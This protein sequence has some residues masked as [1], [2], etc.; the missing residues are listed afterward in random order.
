MK[1]DIRDCNKRIDVVE[2]NANAQIIKRDMQNHVL[3]R[4][5][6]RGDF[7]VSGMPVL[8]NIAVAIATFH[9]INLS[10]QDVTYVCYINNHMSL[11]VGFKTPED[12]FK[13][14][15]DFLKEYSW[16]YQEANTC[17]IKSNILSK[18]PKEFRNYFQNI[19]NHDLN[20]FPLVHLPLKAEPM[21]MEFRRRLSSLIPQEAFADPPPLE[22][23]S[24]FKT[25]NF[26]KMNL[27]KRHEILRLAQ[28]I[29]TQLQPREKEQSQQQT[30]ESDQEKVVLID[31]G[32]GLGYLSEMLYKLNHNY[33]I[34]GLE[35]DPVRVEAAEKRL[36]AYMPGAKEAI[37]YRQQFI[38]ENSKDFINES[39]TELLQSNYCPRQDTLR[40]PTTQAIIG[41]HACADL[42]ITS[43]KLFLRMPQ[44]RHLIIMP[45]CYHKMQMCAG[46]MKFH[47]FPL[48]R[49]LQ[50]V[51]VPDEDDDDKASDSS[52]INNYSSYLNRPFLRL[53]CQ[54]TLKR[55]HKC[56]VEQH[57]RHA[58]EMF[59]RAM[60]EA[61]PHKETEIVVKCKEK[62]D[63]LKENIL[64]FNTIR[65]LYQLQETRDVSRR[66]VVDWSE[67]HVRE[68]YMLVAKYGDGE[69]LAEGLTCL[70]TAIQK[71]CENLVLYDRLCFMEETA[72][73]LNLN[74][75]VRYEKLMDE[76]LSPR[77]Y[78]LIAEKL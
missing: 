3:H 6:N 47:N 33:L 74:I 37:H 35:S 5:L 61:L 2:S 24:H 38:T 69:K 68:F 40:Q 67:E 21:L 43:M 36:E 57:S 22:E 13:E 45:C 41:L 30:A 8:V 73:E 25:E 60:V 19:N 7:G 23:M 17:F 63:L 11:P 53:A 52:V 10:T 77:C 72:A 78:V 18:M 34:L 48:S 14:T 62:I 29:H 28:A 54:Q 27:K 70:Q 75:Y 55:W 51:V 76:E 59:L 64:D 26:R 15:L 46:T 4:R 44:V 16:I 9:K 39:V 65:H 58:R 31:F 12:Y 42:T 71:L 32:C 56:T 50:K 20:Q 66:V 49:R 1:A